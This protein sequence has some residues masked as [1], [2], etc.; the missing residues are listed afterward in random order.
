[1]KRSVFYAATTSAIIVFLT[2]ITDA[3]HSDYVSLL[4][5]HRGVVNASKTLGLA[6]KFDTA[7]AQFYISTQNILSPW[8]PM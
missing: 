8:A 2:W 4:P 6:G 3:R 5:G 7:K 1:M